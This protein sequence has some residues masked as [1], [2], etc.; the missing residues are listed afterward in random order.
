MITG[1]P[2]R[3]IFPAV[4][5]V[6]CTSPSCAGSLTASGD[7]VRGTRPAVWMSCAAWSAVSPTTLGIDTFGM[8]LEKRRLTAEPSGCCV[9]PGGSVLMIVPAGWLVDDVRLMFPTLSPACSRFALAVGR[10]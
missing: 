8:P 10:S 3:T 2:W 1:E 4:G 7:G 9:S 6:F 5:E